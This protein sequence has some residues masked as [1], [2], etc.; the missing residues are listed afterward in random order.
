M[1][2]SDQV[3]EAK[4]L[5]EDTLN[6]AYLNLD[7]DD[8]ARIHEAFAYRLAR[9]VDELADDFLL[10]EKDGGYHGAPVILRSIL[11]TI[12]SLGAVVSDQTF[13]AN[14]CIGEINE[15][16]KKLE[17]SDPELESDLEDLREKICNDYSLPTNPKNLKIWEI[18]KLAGMEGFYQVQYYWLCKAT[19]PT[20][21]GTIEAESGGT[22]GMRGSTLAFVLASASAFLVQVV[23]TEEPQ[24]RIDKAAEILKFASTS[25]E[26]GEV[27][28]LND[29][30]IHY[31]TELT[32]YLHAQLKQDG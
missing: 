1:N 4:S 26:N 21:G 25:H 27:R 17:S 30:E 7:S 22:A 20:L 32:S 6:S 9:H 28:E 14:K 18:A 2:L 8:D 31:K 13:A 5:L 15:M 16:I 3:A 23:K 10:L 11:E 12:F 19:H 24:E 29:D